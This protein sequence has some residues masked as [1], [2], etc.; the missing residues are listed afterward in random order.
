MVARPADNQIPWTGPDVT[1]SKLRASVV[2]PPGFSRAR[3][4]LLP[5]RFALHGSVRGADWAWLQA[6]ND[7]AWQSCGFLRC[8]Q[9]TADPDRA[10]A[11]RVATRAAAPD[12]RSIPTARA[13]TVRTLQRWGMD[14]VGENAGA[15]V[16]ELMTNALRHGLPELPEDPT[17]SSGSPIRLGLANPGPY[18]VCAVTDASPEPPT[19][20]H[21]DWQDEAGRGLSVVAALSDQWG[22]AFEP[23][24]QGKVVWAA[25]A[26]ESPVH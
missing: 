11:P 25:F 2:T 18:V 1:I 3:A 13:F 20:R 22:C 24:G 15:V 6:A 12:A 23:T 17:H 7:M 19:P 4:A 10:P 5:P 21:P 14:H 16:T 26:T 9:D 8:T